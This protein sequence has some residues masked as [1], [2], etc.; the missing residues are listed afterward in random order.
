MVVC[1]ALGMALSACH[2]GAAPRAPGVAG[3]GDVD[4]VVWV[5]Y[6]GEPRSLDVGQ[7]TAGYP[8]MTASSNMCDSLLRMRPDLSVTSGLAEAAGHP[9]PLTYVFRLRQGATFWDG[10]P[11][12]AADAVFSLRRS[13]QPTAA[14]AFF[15]SNVKAVDQR[16]ADEIVIRLLT[17]EVSFP[18]YLASGAGTVAE[19]AYVEAKGSAYGT[20]EGGVMCSGPFRFGTWRRGTS[21]TMVRNDAYWDR[22]LLPHVRELE[23]R[24]I[25]DPATLTTALLTGEVDGTFGAPPADLD[26][27]AGSPAGR[28]TQGPSLQVAGISVTATSGPLADPRI[29]RALS[30]AVD[31]TAFAKAVYAGAADPVHSAILPE[32]WSYER[33]TFQAAY[34]AL[35][36]A[37]PEV[38]RAR[39][40]VKDA[41]SPAAELVIAASPDPTYQAIA[42]YAQSIAKQ[43]GLSARIKVYPSFAQYLSLFYDAKARQGIDAMVNINYTPVV[44]PLDFLASIAL[45]TGL[46]NYNGYS[47][48]KVTALIQRAQ[49]SEAVADRARW[50]TQADAIYEQAPTSVMLATIKINLWQS[51]RVTGAPANASYLSAPWGAMLR[52][53]EG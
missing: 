10:K 24:F 52:P 35:P 31:R 17:P 26:R 8:E 11:V 22:S 39:Q 28:L 53:V 16:G 43:I 19:Q 45:P 46:N 36:G 15:L 30:I 20:P 29:R 40:L 37:A 5:P 25:T 47:D 7:V 21:M 23:L 27:L 4:K 12:T 1:L 6:L 2:G 51:N 49:S 33:P 13:I 18:L 44:E 41:G 48:P 50:I 9:D 38:D 3:G 42:L 32:T 14:N 34:D